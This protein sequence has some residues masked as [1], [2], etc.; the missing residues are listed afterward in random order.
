MIYNNSANEHFAPLIDYY[1]VDSNIKRRL[2]KSCQQVNTI[3]MNTNKNSYTIIYAAVMVVVA[4]L[5]A[6]VS[7]IFEEK[8]T[9][10]VELGKKKQIL[11]SLN[12][13]TAGRDAEALLQSVHPGKQSHQLPG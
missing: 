1:V 7:G 5:L 8:Q 13:S 12:I 4:L 6:L 9:A 2:K 3:K 10:N 11:S